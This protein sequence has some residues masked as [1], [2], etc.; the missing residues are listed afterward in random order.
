MRKREKY[1]KI[2]KGELKDDYTNHFLSHFG[3]HDE[4]RSE[5]G[6]GKY[7]WSL[8]MPKNLQS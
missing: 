1:I 8:E 2:E 3:F 6:Y 5:Y 7:I 4:N